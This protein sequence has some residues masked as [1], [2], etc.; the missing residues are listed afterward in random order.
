MFK[1]I[2]SKD[3]INV[4][5][6]KEMKGLYKDLVCYYIEEIDEALQKSDTLQRVA[7]TIDQYKISLS[8]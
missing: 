5:D 6:L 3:K 7:S 2:V 1:K 4:R 8:V